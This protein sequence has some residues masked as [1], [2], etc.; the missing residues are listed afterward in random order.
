MSP[1]ISHMWVG[2]SG[3]GEERLEVSG[4]EPKACVLPL[5]LVWFDVIFICSC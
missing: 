2:W 3:V 1:D 5:T 4:G